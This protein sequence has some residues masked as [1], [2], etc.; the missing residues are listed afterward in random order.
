MDKQMQILRCPD[1]RLGF[2]DIG[3]CS[4]EKIFVDHLGRVHQFKCHECDLNFLSII[5]LKYHINY[6]HDTPCNICD[7]F[8]G[9]KCAEELGKYMFKNE[10]ANKAR[11]GRIA[12]LEEEVKHEYNLKSDSIIGLKERL[13]NTAIMIDRG[14]NDESLL[15][16]CS[17]IYLPTWAAPRFPRN[18]ERSQSETWVK[19]EGYETS[20]ER[21]TEDAEGAENS[22]M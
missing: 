16:M 19:L 3:N 4:A 2:V 8:C 9:N 1:C 5:H 18:T 15:E 13:E 6:S 21:Q 7:S 17:V 14:S 12:D 11:A 10:A 22:K 20:H